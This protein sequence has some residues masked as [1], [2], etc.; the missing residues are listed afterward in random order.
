MADEKISDLPAA[1]AV[2][3]SDILPI[4]QSGTTKQ[5]SVS[6]LPSSA[7]TGNV[8]VLDL[9]V[10]NAADAYTEGIKILLPVV[11]G[12]VITAV[13]FLVDNFVQDNQS[14]VFFGSGNDVSGSFGPGSG[15]AV[16]GQQFQDTLGLI[17]DTG[18]NMRCDA[19]PLGLVSG[20]TLGALP[21]AWVTNTLYAKDDW[22]LKSNH[23]QQV[24]T[25]GTSDATTEPTWPTDGG[26]VGDGTVV[27]QDVFD[28]SLS[29]STVHAIAEVAYIQ[30]YVALRPD[31]LE[32]IQQPTD[33][34]AGEAFDPVIQVRILD[35]N[36]DPF[37]DAN[38]LG[39]DFRLYVLGAG[40][41]SFGLPATTTAD[42]ETGIASFD[43]LA[44]D[45][46]TPADTYQF[47]L[48]FRYDQLTV[49]LRLDSDP[50]DVTAP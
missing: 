21:R 26:T 43:A 12:R 19:G 33:V 29:T 23:V 18:T 47:V 46:G 7:G 22:V 11:D 3:V 42:A 32:F 1:T 34:V 44:M 8:A 15:F 10:V 17:G 27:W 28:I 45:A 16:F 24:V 50:F 2:S 39:T 14:N 36:G 31:A 13:R 49:S 5:A 40:T 9:G 6:L 35:Q 38:T 30:D 48:Q 20:L 41:T 25:G 4:V 37:I